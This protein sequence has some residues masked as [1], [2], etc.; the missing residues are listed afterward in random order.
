[1]ISEETHSTGF[2]EAIIIQSLPDTL[3]S[4]PG[5]EALHPQ[6]TE[7]SHLF[8]RHQQHLPPA[9]HNNTKT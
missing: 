2:C 6:T 7:P 5:G 3:R 9:Q 1:M 4:Y 8:L